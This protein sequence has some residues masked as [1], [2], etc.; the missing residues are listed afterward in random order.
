[1]NSGNDDKRD[2]NTP[3]RGAGSDRKV[4]LAVRMGLAFVVSLATMVFLRVV[5]GI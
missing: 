5:M 3:P 2:G 1:M 4:S